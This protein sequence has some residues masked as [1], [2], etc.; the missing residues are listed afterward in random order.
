MAYRIAC[1]LVLL[2]GLW[3][4]EAAALG[5]L[6][7]TREGPLP[8]LTL[9]VDEAKATVTYDLER[10]RPIEMR[11]VENN[12]QYLQAV[13]KSRIVVLTKRTRDLLYVWVS[14]S[15]VGELEGGAVRGRCTPT[16]GTR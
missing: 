7:C 11:I 15:R 6:S 3:P 14:V 1:A 2:V 9:F 8:E 5:F 12:P 10:N 13:A 16:T 4:R